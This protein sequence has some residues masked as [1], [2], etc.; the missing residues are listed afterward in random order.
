MTIPVNSVKL[1]KL[2]RK[3]ILGFILGCDQGKKGP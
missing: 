1:R 2:V 3:Q